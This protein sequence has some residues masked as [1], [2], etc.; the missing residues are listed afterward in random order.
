MHSI[1]LRKIPLLLSTA[2]TVCIFTFFLIHTAP[3]DRL[4]SYLGQEGAPPAERDLIRQQLGLD[5]GVVTQF[6]CYMG[7]LSS[8]DLGSIPGKGNVASILFRRFLATARLALAA[9]VLSVIVG[10]T[11]GLASGWYANTR[12]DRVVQLIMI[13]C[14][15]TPIFWFGL[16]MLAIFAWALNLFP[17]AGSDGPAYLVLPAL[18]LG[19]RPAALIAR[20]ARANT[21][22]TK[23][24]TFV[25]AAK[26]RGISLPVLLFKHILKVVSIP[27]VTIVGMDFASLLSGAVITETVFSYQ[28]LGLFA[29]EAISNRWYDAV[30]AVALVWAG[31]FIL[32]NFVVDLSYAVLDPRTRGGQSA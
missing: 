27:V 11:A 14:V 10:L 2:L 25:L 3:G 22:D 19:L 21:I 15:S 6:F 18:T 12:F 5:E 20:V 13:F 26:A 30:M 31:I 23:G 28:G 7:R 17:A 8:G 29:I 1:F 9:I 4:D 32:A 24:E 16:V